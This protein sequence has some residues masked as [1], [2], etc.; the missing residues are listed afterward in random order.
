MQNN[1]VMPSQVIEL[2]SVDP[3]FLLKEVFRVKLNKIKLWLLIKQLR[4]ILVAQIQP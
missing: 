3:T 1:L 4:S 2:V